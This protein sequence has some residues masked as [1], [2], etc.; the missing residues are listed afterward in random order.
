MIW[1][2]G[3]KKI[4]DRITF[5]QGRISSYPRCHLDSQFKN[6]YKTKRTVRSGDTIISLTTDAGR[7]SQ[8]NG[9][10]CP[11]TAPSAVHLMYCFRPG[12]QHPGLSVR[13]CAPLSPLHRFKGMLQRNAAVVKMGVLFGH[14]R[15][16]NQVGLLQGRNKSDSIISIGLSGLRCGI[17]STLLPARA[18][19]PRYAGQKR[20]RSS[21]AVR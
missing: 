10:S 17:V 12:S 4:P 1:R 5:H 7:A 19:P 9:T 16:E 15:N 11:L 21:S 13:S 20:S 14:G 6:I 8:L 2:A 3:Q 18:L